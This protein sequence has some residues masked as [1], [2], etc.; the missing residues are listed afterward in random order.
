MA[1]TLAT[2]ALILM[3][4]SRTVAG[5]NK[6]LPGYRATRFVV[7][8]GVKLHYVDW[9]GRGDTLL[10]LAGLGNDAYVFDSFARH[11]TDRFRVL[12]LTRR[13]FGPSSKPKDGYD[14]NTRVEDIRAVLDALKVGRVHLAGHSIAGDE[15]T[16]FAIRHPDRVRKLVYLDAAFN[17]YRAMSIMSSDPAITP[18]AKRLYLELVGDPRAAQVAASNL[19]RRETWPA[20]FG[21]MRAADGFRPDYRK[22]SAPALAIYAAVSQAHPLAAKAMDEAKRKQL[23]AWWATNGAPRARSSI[24]QF[25]REMRRG[26][27]VEMSNANHYLFLGSTQGEVAAMTRA[28]LLR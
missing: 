11:F 22:I 19:P 10:L 3:A 15:I 20:L 2:L 5:E 23:N 7:A 24:E 8:N 26:E 12:A 21:C 9:G 14:L 4:F 25:K 13:G 28:F 17:R 1:R 6:A 27:V 16:S 18:E